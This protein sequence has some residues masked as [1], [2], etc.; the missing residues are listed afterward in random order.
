MGSLQPAFSLKQ[1]PDSPKRDAK[2][3]EK[4]KKRVL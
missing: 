3:E 1:S 4:Q 2:E